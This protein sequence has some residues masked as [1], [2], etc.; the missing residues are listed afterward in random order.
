MAVNLPVDGRWSLPAMVEARF[1]RL[2]CRSIDGSSFVLREQ[3]GRRL[4]Q[5]DDIEAE[6][7]RAHHIAAAQITADKLNVT[8]LSAITANIG[9]LTITDTNGA[10]GWLYQGT[11]TG[12]SPTTGLKIFNVGGIGKLSTYNTEV[13]QITLDTDGKLKWAEGL[14]WLNAAGMILVQTTS[15]EDKRSILFTKADGV[16]GIGRLGGSYATSGGVTLESVP[17]TGMGGFVIVNGYAPSGELARVMLRAQAGTPSAYIDLRVTGGVQTCEIA[18]AGGV[19]LL[20]GLN[21]GT[22]TTAGTG[23]VFLSGTIQ[24]TT[25]QTFVS[26]TGPRIYK[27]STGGM[28]LQAATGSTYDF[29]VVTPTGGNILSV[30]TGTNNI[31]LEGKIGFN[32][33]NPITKPTVTGSR[34][35]DAWRTSLMA[36][37]ANYGL[38][39]DSSTA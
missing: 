26:S 9:F 15:L 2:Y 7:I 1:I 13:E 20:H 23:D 4:I 30:L 19:S 12:D 38:V 39:T 35:T 37:L 22:P 14:A 5:A 28:L 36:A 17:Q 18:A 33:T 25:N 24:L 29:S 3:Y 34:A 32:A 27:T 6:A 11:G 8:E 31:R 16:T 10:P 21:V